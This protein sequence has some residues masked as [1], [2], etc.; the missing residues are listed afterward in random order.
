MSGVKF[1][2]EF[3]MYPGDPLC[4]HSTYIVS[5]H[6]PTQQIPVLDIVAMARVARATRKKRLMCSWD[7]SSDIAGGRAKVEGKLVVV[8]FEGQDG[9]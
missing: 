3:L 2:G 5:I 8:G 6:N 1:G 4:N 9:S 7:G